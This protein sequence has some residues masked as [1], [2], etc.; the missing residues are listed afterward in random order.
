MKKSLLLL[1]AMLAFSGSKALAVTDA[2]VQIILNETVGR[3]CFI[4]MSTDFVQSNLSGNLPLQSHVEA[5]LDNEIVS[6]NG[7]LAPVTRG[8]PIYETCNDDFKM[9]YTSTNS[10]LL[11]SRPSGASGAAPL[12]DYSVSYTGTID[13]TD[14]S[15]VDVAALPK[16]V[17][18]PLSGV[19]AANSA[20]GPGFSIQHQMS[21]FT[22]SIPQHASLPAGA[23][24]DTLLIEMASN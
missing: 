17:E 6:T 5:L 9:T 10:G 19:Q 4:A 3:D 21:T 16:T 1:A 11:G 13:G 14:F 2:D 18:R 15:A 24:T 8:W 7:T 22:I 23:Y 20:Q 12:V